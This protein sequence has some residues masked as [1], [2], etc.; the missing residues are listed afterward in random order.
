MKGYF[1]MKKILIIED[2]RNLLNELR[3]FLENRGYEVS[4]VDNF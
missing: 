4:S 3:E 1:I 2:D